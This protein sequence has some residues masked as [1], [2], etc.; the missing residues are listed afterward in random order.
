MNYYDR[1]A[2]GYD[3]LH[4][5]EQLTKLQILLQHAQ[6]HGKILDVGAGTCIVAKHLGKQFTVISVDP[7]KKMLD[8]GIGERH[9]AK[10]EQL[11]FAAKT[12]DSIISLT[13]LHHC[14]L[15]QALSEIQRV[16]KPKAVIALTFLQKSSKLKQFE[17][18][19]QTFFGKYEKLEANQDF[20]Y[21]I[22]HS[23]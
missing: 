1:L 21:L 17:R 6:F 10:A 18:L 8:Q 16:A 4:A 11:P 22:K 3:E 5:E 23:H 20:L 15:Q 19:L 14:D 9:V 7:S 13:V 2:P 12:F